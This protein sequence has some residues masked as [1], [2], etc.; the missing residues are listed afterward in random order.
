LAER[1]RKHLNKIQAEDVPIDIKPV[2]PPDIFCAQPQEP[3][4]F[5]W[6]R[7]RGYIG[8]YYLEGPLAATLPGLGLKALILMT[9]G[10][11]SCGSYALS[12]GEVW[13]FQD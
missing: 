7:A 5:F 2:N 9:E 12:L 10:W 13:G 3:K 6:V 8:G 11:E 1:Y 4:Q